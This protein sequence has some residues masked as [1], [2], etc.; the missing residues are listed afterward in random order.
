MKHFFMK[1]HAYLLLTS[2]F[3]ISILAACNGNSNTAE[4]TPSSKMGKQLLLDNCGACHNLPDRNQT[5]VAP[6]FLAIKQ[7]YPANS[8]EQFKKDIAYFLSNPSLE[9]SKMK[10]AVKEYGIMPK[11]GYS[12]SDVNS[13]LDYLFNED[14]ENFESSEVES[15]LDKPVVSELEMRKKIAL[16]TKSILG[17]NL[18]KAMK[19]NGPVGAIGFCNEKALLLSDS[20]GNIEQANIKRVTNKPRNPANKANKDEL[21]IL[22]SLQLEENKGGVLTERNGKKIGY[23]KIETNEMCLKCHGDLEKDIS[24]KTAEKISFLYPN[25]LATGYKPNQL[26]GMWVVE[27]PKK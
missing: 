15:N 7:S 2:L 27:L 20:M 26:R 11:M 24:K 10:S 25:D 8:I 6:S 14:L 5:G 22:K 16:K 3:I 18:M 21:N 1:K 9:K 17:K 23:F 19:E 12:E 4:N 13:I